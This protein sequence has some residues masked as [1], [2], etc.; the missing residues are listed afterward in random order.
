MPETSPKMT[1][2]W[3]DEASLARRRPNLVAR[4]RMNAA[5]RRLFEAQGFTEVETAAL[6]VSPGLEPHLQA[7]ATDLRT[8]D[9]RRHRRYLHT[10]PEFACKKL[11]AAGEGRIFTFA[12]VWRNDERSARHH[13]E[14]TLLEW[15]R[16]PGS[17]RD[18]I[19]DCQVLLRGV[20]AALGITAYR[21][22]DLACDPFAAWQEITVVEACARFAEID[23][24][25]SLADPL[26]PDRDILAAQA[27]RSGLRVAADDSW[28]DLF[29]KLMVGR[30]EPR[31]GREVPTV[32]LDYPLPEAA[33]ARRKKEDPRLAERLELYVAGLELANGFGELTDP[34]EQRARFVADQALKER[35][36]GERYPLDEELLQAIGRIGE[37]A[38]IAL[39]IDRLAMLATGAPRIEDVLW[40]PV[41]LPPG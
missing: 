6:Q 15:Y 39:G 32:L 41:D 16:S 35:L 2:F 7:F 8:P 11:L 13:P 25:A 29:T 40:A 26:A 21:H 22:A 24:L 1:E 31:L 20:A 34:A 3:W 28:A 23:L 18:L 10:S 17:Y 37:A 14:F 38:G 36:Y 30:V 9:G 27:T 33:L 12:R 5:L 19:V 4:N